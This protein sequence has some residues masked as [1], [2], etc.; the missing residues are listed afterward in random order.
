MRDNAS[1]SHHP[2]FVVVVDRCVL[3]ESVV[4][5]HILRGVIV[6]RSTVTLVLGVPEV[7]P[8]LRVPVTDVHFR[9]A[10]PEGPIGQDRRGARVRV[11]HLAVALRHRGNRVPTFGSRCQFPQA[12]RYFLFLGWLWLPSIHGWH[13]PWD[14][15]AALA[16]VRSCATRNPR[17]RVETLPRTSV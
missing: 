10:R 17:H 5:R 4:A 2:V 9:L 3:R 15:Q 11:T 6:A 13:H 1:N 7:R 16:I 8:E 14:L 12:Q